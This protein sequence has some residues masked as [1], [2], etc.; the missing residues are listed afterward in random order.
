MHTKNAA[1]VFPDPVGAEIS[2]VFRSKIGGQP[3]SCG[4]VGVPNRPTN[5]S[6]ISGC[7]HSS[8]R[9][10][11]CDSTPICL[12]IEYSTKRRLRRKDLIGAGSDYCSRRASARRGVDERRQGPKG[13]SQIDPS[14]RPLWSAASRRRLYGCQLTP[15]PRSKP[16]A[17]AP[18]NPAPAS[19]APE[20]PPQAPSPAKPRAASSLR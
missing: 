12:I 11:P 3:N 10:A 4:S 14:P 16:Q 20:V 7:A 18:T 15:K 1:S 2:V 5:Q 19:S 8:P 9:G 6:R 13:R 17:S